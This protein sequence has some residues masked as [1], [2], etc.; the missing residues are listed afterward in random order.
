MPRLIPAL[1]LLLLSAV[2][3]TH[4]ADRVTEGEDTYVV[5]GASRPALPAAAWATRNG[6]RSVSGP[7]VRRAPRRAVRYD[8][9]SVSWPTATVKVLTFHQDRG[10]VLHALTDETHL[11]VLEGRIRTTVSGQSVTLGAGDVASLPTGSL[12][13]ADGP[14]SARV[15]AWTAGSLVPGAVPA[16]VALAALPPPAAGPLTLRRYDFPGN[17]IRAVSMA[18][19]FKTNPNSAKTDSLIYVTRGPMQ[20]MQNGRTFTV[21]AGDFIREVAGLQHHWDVTEESGFVTTS[22]LPV[23]AGPID[24]NKA[25]DRPR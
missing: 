3:A 10:G 17:S 18:K 8:I 6:L 2:P 5:A 7:A 13:N 25:T 9:Q 4:A 14:G 1:V 16:V 24:P 20:F 23:G 12:Q 15:V 19:G 21:T 11:Y 22:A